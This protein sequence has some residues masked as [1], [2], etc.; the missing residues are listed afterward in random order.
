[1]KILGVVCSPRQRGNTD[2]LV[3]T[4]LESAEREGAEVELWSYV[5][6]TV[7][8]CDHCKSCFK[9][10]ECHFK[11]DMQDLYLKMIGADGI[12]F[13]SPV[14]FWSVSAQ[15][16][17]VIDRT[18]ALRRPTNKLRGKVGGAI[19]V[20]GRQG[21]IGALTVINNFFLGQGMMPTGL[22]VNGRGSDKGDVKK[23]E[24]ALTDAVELGRRMVEIILRMQQ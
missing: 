12:I 23:D 24:R 17:L 15:A 21:Q 4:A 8:P 9:K 22:G 2:I 1:M 5:G 7:M 18:Y 13:G 20:A 10:G 16:K 14:Y 19:V 3:N 11:D 6:K